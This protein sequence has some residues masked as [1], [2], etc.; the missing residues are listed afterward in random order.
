MTG[1][2]KTFYTRALQINP[3]YQEAY[4]NLG[5]IA[6]LEGNFVEARQNFLTAAKPQQWLCICSFLS[7]PTL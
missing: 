4:I 5:I 2:A 6:E 7:G 3:R 1:T